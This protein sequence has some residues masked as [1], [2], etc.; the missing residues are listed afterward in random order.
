MHVNSA[1]VVTDVEIESAEG[2]G[3]KMKARGIAAGFLSLFPPDPSRGPQGIT[4]RRVLNF[5]PDVV[6]KP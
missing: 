1:G 6:V 5:Q 2:V 3:E 4:Y